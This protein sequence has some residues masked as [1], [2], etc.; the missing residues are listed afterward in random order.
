MQELKGYEEP[1]MQVIWIQDR[2]IDTLTASSGDGD[3]WEFPQGWGPL[4]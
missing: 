3:E 2:N 1:V 4:D